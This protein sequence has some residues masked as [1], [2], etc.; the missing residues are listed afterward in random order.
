MSEGSE[1]DVVV[2]VDIGGTQIKGAVVTCHGVMVASE[3]TPTAVPEGPSAVAGQVKSLVDKLAEDARAA[4]GRDPLAVGLVVPGVI[5]PEA[6][7]VRYAANIGWSDLDLRSQVAAVLDVPVALGHDGRA[8]AVAEGTFG[9][10]R[11]IDDFLFVALGTGIGGC[12]VLGGVAHPGAHG[13]SGEIGHIKA[14]FDGPRCACGEDGCL[15]SVAS[16]AAITRRYLARGGSTDGRLRAS[17]VLRRAAEGDDP[18]AASVADDAI[19]ALGTVLTMVQRLVDV[20]LVV[21]GGGL[22]AAGDALLGPLAKEWAKRAAYQ[23][24]PRL[25][26]SGLGSHAGSY[27]AAVLAWQ[28]IGRRPSP[29]GCFSD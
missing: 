28:A 17:D 8:G 16:A 12:A 7:V 18:I 5:D 26:V 22:C 29:D 15:E 10:A 24:P 6:G 3:R 14:L 25:A 2:A 11:G 13:L 21:I 19:D 23:P 4:S 1:T 20:D 27:G 9:V